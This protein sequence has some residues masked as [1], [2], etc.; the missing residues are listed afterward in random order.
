MN[1]LIYYIYIYTVKNSN[2]YLKET[3]L[4]QVKVLL[5]YDYYFYTKHTVLGKS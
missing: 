1:N 2:I 5:L 3:D 4:S